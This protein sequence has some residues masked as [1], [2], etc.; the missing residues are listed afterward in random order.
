MCVHRLIR[1]GLAEKTFKSNRRRSESHRHLGEKQRELPWQR[2]P[3][4]C[5]PEVFEKQ[6]EG[7]NGLSRGTGRGSSRRCGSQAKCTVP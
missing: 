3:V 6:P 2:P 7:Q 4:G 1:M 5:M